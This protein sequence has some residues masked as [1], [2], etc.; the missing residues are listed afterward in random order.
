[1]ARRRGGVKAMWTRGRGAKHT[2]RAERCWS[3]AEEGGF[4]IIEVMAAGSVI[5]VIL[6]S[7]AY[8]TTGSLVTV[9]CGKQRQAADGLANQVIEQVRALPLSTV[10]NGMNANDPTLATDANLQSASGTYTY[11]PTNETVPVGSFGSGYTQ[12]PLSP[13]QTT[14][15]LDSTTY[16]VSTYITRYAAQQGAYRA[17][18]NVSWSGGSCTPSGHGVTT[19]TIL[20]SGTD[21]GGPLP[22]IPPPGNTGTPSV[23]QPSFSSEADQ[24]PGVIQITGTVGSLMV[25]QAELLLPTLTCT[26]AEGSRS[27]GQCQGVTSGAVLDVVGQTVARV[28]QQ[29]VSCMVNTQNGPTS[30]TAPVSQ[31]TVSTLSGGS[32]VLSLSVSPGDSGNL[33][34]TTAAS[35]SP[36]CVDLVSRAQ[37][38]GQ[39]CSSGNIALAG[40]LQATASLGALGL[41]T[42]ASV[43]ASPSASKVFNTGVVSP[44][45]TYCANTSGDGC[46][47]AGATRKIGQVGI[48]GLPAGLGLGCGGYFLQLTGYSDSVSAESGV[49]PASPTASQSS[50]G[51]SPTISVWNGVSCVSVPLSGALLPLPTVN[52]PLTAGGITITPTVSGGGVST[53][54]PGGG[55]ASGS[56]SPILGD[57]Q[58]QVTLLGTTL[59]NVDI[60]ID[61]GTLTAATSYQAV[62]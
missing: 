41:T 45:G 9:S 22:G 52:I 34:A 19:Q 4:T 5:I 16:T 38:N 11:V 48:V 17:I 24:G 54:T 23:L 2:H 18:A 43:G 32:S 31:G 35:P 46:V 30:C 40:S 42:L 12:Q 6:T 49:M 7:M 57:I 61:L 29:T 26:I 27:Q 36:A 50:S 51:G 13:H 33:L 25:N 37:T 59:A 1:M 14:T 44:G 3:R 60:H 15:T 39:P 56:A 10:A 8:V 62:P 55:S 58:L 53:A 21:A 47:H 20:G 28:G